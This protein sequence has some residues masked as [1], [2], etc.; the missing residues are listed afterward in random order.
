M[1]QLFRPKNEAELERFEKIVTDPIE[2]LKAVRTK[3]EADPSTPFKPFPWWKLYIQWYVRLF[4]KF[5][6]LLVPKS[7]RML[8]SWTN[9][10]LV[11]WYSMFRVGRLCGVVSKKEDDAD[12][13][14]NRMKFIYENL[15]P[16]IIPPGWL[17]EM[18][19]V[20]G[21][22][23]FKSIDSKIMGF[24]QGS[25]Q[26]RQYG[27]SII[28]ADEMA[29]WDYA[30]NMYNSAF[31]TIQGE[32]GKILGKFL[33]ISSVGPGFFKRLV[34][35]Q[36]NDER[37]IGDLDEA[38]LLR[39]QKVL[40]PAEGIRIWK[41]RRNQFVVCDLHYTADPAKRAD[42][43]KRNTKG[44]MSSQKYDQEMEKDWDVYSGKPVYPDFDKNIHI[45]KEAIEP[46]LGIPLLR[47]WDFGLTP[48]AIV[49]QYVDEQLLILREFTSASIGTD[50]FSDIVLK[51]C[52]ILYPA[53]REQFENWRDFIDP[54]GQNRAESDETTSADILSEKGLHIIP[55]AVVWE[56]RRASVEDYLL[57]R[58]KRGSNLLISEP[59]CPKLIQGFKGGYAYPEKAFDIE[60]K[61]IRPVKNIYSHPHD[62]LQMIS[63][64][65]TMILNDPHM[66]VP[67]PQYGF[68]TR[69]DPA[70]AMVYD[71]RQPVRSV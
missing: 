16:D 7:R 47:G 31:P 21:E 28:L 46:V 70:P 64:G 20:Y 48:A 62:A 45:T 26:L 2:F 14:L 11:L 5:N 44:S 35:D 53:W 37:D 51:Q 19:K 42:E 8:M 32:G 15:D 34:F 27:F 3:D 59:Y 23:R 13:L 52:K 68:N 69:N 25:D 29:F 56:T 67:S 6:L 49:A 36:L 50:R 66:N 58:T 17:P 10:A 40:E 18:E 54:A 33:G 22:I 30:E 1:E 9:V 41:N 60:P 4:M 71:G 55:G 61:K 24:P 63:T 43:F 65:L 39:G 57:S 38:E 12:D